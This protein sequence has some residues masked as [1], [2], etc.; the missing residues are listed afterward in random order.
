MFPGQ[1]GI[2]AATELS[3]EIGAPPEELRRLSLEKNHAGV[4]ER[5]WGLQARVDPSVTFEEFTFWAKIERE[6]EVQENKHF[7]KPASKGG[8]FGFLKGKNK[9]SGSDNSHELAAQ[10]GN[11]PQNE[12]TGAVED[13]NGDV[14]A[15]APSGTHDY[16]AEWRK[17]ARALR[18]VGWVNI[19]YLIT[20]DI[21]GWSQ[22][23]Y[24]FANTGYGLG[25][26]LFI[27]MG[28]A[29][30]A[31][32]MMIWWTFIKLDSSRYPIVSFGD[33][34]FRLFGP[35][36]RH[37]INIM[38]SIQM[39]LSVCVIMLAQTGILKQML[40]KSC[41]IG[42]GVFSMVVCFIGGYMRSLKA[43]GWFANSAVWINIV[44]FIIM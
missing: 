13:N 40:P 43:I 12:K 10:N 44:S 34:F 1:P 23:P 33:A 19:F 37:F 39:F 17:S 42:L 14:I 36:T 24:V 6:M 27:L 15:I 25:T 22:T 21:L 11:G 7:I 29:A 3:K 20:T 16:D 9:D 41:F 26:G 35:Y 8:M 4:L 38:Q 2:T 32:A 30:F 5:Q 28:L 31:S 18:T